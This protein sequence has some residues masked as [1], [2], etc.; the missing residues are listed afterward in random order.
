MYP[1]M[2][3]YAYLRIYVCTYIFT[4]AY[5]YHI[6]YTI[7]RTTHHLLHIQTCVDIDKYIYNIYI[8]L[9]LYISISIYIYIFIY[10]YRYIF[11][12]IYISL[13]IGQLS[14]ATSKNPS[15]MNT[16]CINSF[17]YTHVITSTKLRLKQTW[18]L[19]KANEMWH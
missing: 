9:Y 13:C 6:P 4:C 5:H 11:I 2:F 16:I 17:C 19:T 8:S 10:L 1:S 14:I 18:R 3:E 15:V 7:L 12:Y